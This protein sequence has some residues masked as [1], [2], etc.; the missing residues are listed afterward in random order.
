[1]FCGL[2]ISLAFF[3]GKTRALAYAVAGINCPLGMNVLEHRIC[4]LAPAIVNRCHA[5]RRRQDPAGFTLIELLVVIAIIAILAALLLPSLG[6]A[7]EKALTINCLN[8]LKQLTTCWAMYA[9]DNNDTMPP[10][11]NK[12]AR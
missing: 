9:H 8:N 7:K 6:R 12:D 4:G 5:P 10:N 2:I 1:M 11:K 3:S